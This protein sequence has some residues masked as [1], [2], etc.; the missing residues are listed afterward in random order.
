V[1]GAVVV[2]LL[3]ERRLSGWLLR[4]G[5]G[6]A[7]RTAG[8]VVGLHLAWLVGWLVVAVVASGLVAG[9]PDHRAAG[10]VVVPMLVAYGGVVLCFLPGTRP[11]R[12]LTERGVRGPVA[13]AY[14]VAGVPFGLLGLGI[15]TGAFLAAFVP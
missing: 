4:R 3:L 1:G 12:E 11:V 15:C 5:G 7:W 2:A 6:R 13:W 10:W 14:A 8:W 9:E